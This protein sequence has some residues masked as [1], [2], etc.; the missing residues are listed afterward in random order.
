MERYLEQ[1]VYLHA[2][3]GSEPKLTSRL[4]MKAVCNFYLDQQES[5]AA[6]GEIKPRQAYDQTLLLRNFVRYIGPNHTM[7]TISTV[8]LQNY[9]KE[10]IK[11]RKSPNT[12]NNRISAVKAMYNW[13]CSPKTG[14]A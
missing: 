2:G 10:L 3:K 4:S 12:I 6:I 9:R 1:E 14:P 11:S 5:R 7:S 13:A 8:D